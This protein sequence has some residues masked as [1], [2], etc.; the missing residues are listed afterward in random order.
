MLPLAVARPWDTEDVVSLVR[1]AT[2]AGHALVPRGAGTGMPGGN[3]GPH[4]ILEVG[5]F[6]DIGEVRG[7]TVTVGS[8]VTGATVDEVAGNALTL[9]AL[10][11]S[12]L[13]CTIGGMVANNAAGARSYGYGSIRAW[14]EAAEVVTA[15][16]RVMWLERGGGPGPWR[17]LLAELRSGWA[18]AE[19]TWPAVRKNSSGYALGHFLDTTDA[20]DLIVGSE[21]TLGVVTRVRLR[22]APRPDS[23]HV[24]L[25]PVPS[26]EALPGVVASLSGPGVAA[27]EFLGERYLALSGLL[28]HPTY[29]DALRGGGAAVLLE[30]DDRHGTLETDVARVRDVATQLGVRVLSASGGEAA[31][32]WQIRHVASPV[33]AARTPPGH[34]SMQFVEDSVVPPHALA[35][36]LRGLE[37]IL[38][39]EETDA[40][41]FGHAGDGNVHVNPMIDVRHPKWK[42][43][44]GRILHRTAVLVSGLGGTLSG[45]HGDGRIRTPLNPMI[46]EPEVMQMFKTVKATLDP[47]GI[48]NPGVI[49]P[50]KGQDPL[51]GLTA[52]GGLG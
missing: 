38:F 6:Q 26:Q 18:R 34:V 7:D 27:C 11:S 14:V 49:V 13:R 20:L 4:V 50:V 30:V 41:M 29:A 25:V 10:P 12:A 35:R 9:P 45:E 15:E 28:D 5:A 44:V 39:E 37:N 52:L 1:W 32:L 47:S 21:G 17:R 42:E 2:A 46:W 36:Y 22:L 51:A 3:V 40:V 48:L 43:C 19:A 8:G 33:I 31:R 16:G 23:R 24:S